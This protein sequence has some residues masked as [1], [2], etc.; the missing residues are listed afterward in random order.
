MVVSP[1]LTDRKG[2]NDSLLCFEN[3]PGDHSLFFHEVPSAAGKDCCG[4]S[5][6]GHRSFR[7]FFVYE[8]VVLLLL[9]LATY[10]LRIFCATQLL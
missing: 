3:G 1:K 8:I 7:N 4:S 5:R 6:L 9:H 10:P 2:S